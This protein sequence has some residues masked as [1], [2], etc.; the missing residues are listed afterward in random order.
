MRNERLELN[1]RKTVKLT[2]PTSLTGAFVF[3]FFYVK[4]SRAH[5][6]YNRSKIGNTRMLCVSINDGYQ[7]STS[8][9]ILSIKSLAK[10]C[11]VFLDWS[12]GS[13]SFLS[14]CVEG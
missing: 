6:T 7:S 4:M 2:A 14:D 3:L 12:V 1:Y 10:Q 11:S 5:H 9:Q 13:G 8:S